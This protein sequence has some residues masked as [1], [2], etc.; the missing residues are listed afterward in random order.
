M[1][2]ENFI[3]WFSVR[4]N[5]TFLIALVS[6]ALSLWNFFQGLWKNRCAYTISYVNHFCGKHPNGRTVLQLRLNFEVHSSAPVTVTRIF[7]IT[8]QEQYEF[9]FPSVCVWEFTRSRNGNVIKREEI[10]S[11]S[12]PFRM[13]G[14]G[15]LGGYFLVYV[16]DEME[17][18]LNTKTK[19]CLLVQTTK[20]KKHFLLSADNPGRDAEQYGKKR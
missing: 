18:E 20:K 10:S 19:I 5:I 16:P 14:Y 17:K 13:E 1:V 7:L 3:Q 4:E 11:Q 6:F 12:L 15:A 2:Y 8:E 9:I